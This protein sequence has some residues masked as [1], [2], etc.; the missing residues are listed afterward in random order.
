[1]TYDAIIFTGGLSVTTKPFGAYKIA[2]ELRSAGFSTLVIN[3]LEYFSIEELKDILKQT[4]GSNTL[5]V[6]VSNTFFGSMELKN[7][8]KVINQPDAHSF[9]P[10]SHSQQEETE[11]CNYIKTLNSDVKI[12]LGGTRAHY[13]VSNPNIDYVFVGYSDQSVVN[14]AQ[15]LA[16]GVPLQKARKNLSGIIVVD[17]DLAKDFDFANSSMRWCDDDV[18][19]WGE[20]LPLEISRGC[21]FSCKF[22]SYRL[23]GKQAL[24]YLKNYDNIR[25]ELVHNYEQYGVTCYRFV[26][27]TFNDTEEKIDAMLKISESLPFELKFWAYIRLDLLATRPHTIDKLYRMGLRSIFF[28]IETLNK[29]TGLLIGKGFDPDRSVALINNLKQTYGDNLQIHGSFI[30]GLPEESFDSVNNTMQRLLTREI[31]VDT[32][33]FYPLGIAKG[34]THVWQSAFGLDMQQYGYYE[35]PDDTVTDKRLI[36]WKNKYMTFQ[37]AT[38]HVEEFLERTKKNNRF[39]ISPIQK[40]I[41][42]G[43]FTKE[44]VDRHLTRYKKQLHKLLE[45]NRVQSKI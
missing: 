45:R 15:H 30:C 36:P 8:G 33:S 24:D 17:D 4:V 9:L 22:C 18:V 28:G 31:D 3:H 11:L 43:L 19:L 20:A 44:E 27:D 5:F 38:K 26:D 34:S 2:H 1:M 32:Y 35:D 13:N 16:H 39:R 14:F 41:N 40:K 21:I 42:G 6:G 25:N 29:K 12:I 37:Q 7:T 23:N 10:H